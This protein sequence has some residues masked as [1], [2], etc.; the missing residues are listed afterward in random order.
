MA[1]LAADLRHSGGIAA[2][3]SSQ[4]LLVG[5][6]GALSGLAAYSFGGWALVV[7]GYVVML[8]AAIF[9]PRGFALFLAGAVTVIEPAAID[10]SGELGPFLYRFPDDWDTML[11]LTIAPYE[12]LIVITAG[13]LALRRAEPVAASARIPLLAWA[14]P[15]AIAAGLA[16][17][18]YKG[19]PYNLAYNEARGLIY[20]L[21]VFYIAW[22]L[23][24][25]PSRAVLGSILAATGVLAVILLYRY[26]TEV[27]LGQNEVAAQFAFTHE[28]V[29]F[30]GIGTIAAA[31]TMLRAKDARTRILLSAFLILLLAAMMAT[32][33]RSGTLVF[34]TAALVSAWLLLPRRPALVMGLTA[35]TLVLGSVYLAAYWNKT[36]GAA[37]QPARAIRSRIDPSPRDISS[38]TYRDFELANVVITIE[39]HPELG[40]G[41]GNRFFAPF[42]LPEL[43]WWPLQFHTP[44]NNLL[45]LWLKMGIIGAAVFLGTWVIAM[46][47][48]VG[49]VAR[50]PRDAL[51]PALPLV[52]AGTLAM[53]MTFAEVDLVL[54]GTRPIIPLAAAL[55][56]ALALPLGPEQTDDPPSDRQDRAPRSSR[57]PARP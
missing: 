10:V 3:T 15:L 30:L 16:Y 25:M 45:W 51:T 28:A 34:L 7:V 57:R 32:G 41:F 24:D 12:L 27:R 21:A 44:H 37:A 42:P 22:R 18:V 31:V 20:G 35:I 43:P 14:I 38:D 46:S 1:G 56:L 47:R 5:V 11:P 23:R 55:A 52:L 33:R 4:Y 29:I 19:A 6:A 36:T 26:F 54:T 9:A 49:G 13:S 17:G 8:I 39:A 53:Y 2:G 48:C 40:V 50:A